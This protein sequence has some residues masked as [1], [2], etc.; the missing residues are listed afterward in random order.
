MSAR[1]RQSAAMTAARHQPSAAPRASR[2]SA[3]SRF[4]WFFSLT[5]AILIAFEAFLT[6]LPFADAIP[7]YAE[8][9]QQRQLDSYFQMI[10][11]LITL[12]TV[13]IGGITGYVIN[14]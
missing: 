5:V 11:L 8:A 6:S 2:R 13:T 4:Y 1:P 9:L 3:S 12:A 14:R 7:D 10:Q